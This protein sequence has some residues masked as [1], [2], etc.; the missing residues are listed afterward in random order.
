MTSEETK[1]IFVSA[2][3]RI[4]L[5]YFFF[6]ESRFCFQKLFSYSIF[7]FFERNSIPRG[8]YINSSLLGR[9]LETTEF[10]DLKS[11]ASERN[12]GKLCSLKFVTFV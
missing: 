6:A 12:K 8:R 5:L 4:D 7:I 1:C 10:I 11:L 2:E 9:G 3:C